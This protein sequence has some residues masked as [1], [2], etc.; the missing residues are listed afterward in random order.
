MK[1]M[2]A[3]HPRIAKRWAKEQEKKKGKK[4][5]KKLPKKVRKNDSVDG[6]DFAESIESMDFIR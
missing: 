1:Y 2:F 6:F 3:V 5:F 4:S